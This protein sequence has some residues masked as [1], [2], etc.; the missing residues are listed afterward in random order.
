[1]RARYPDRFQD[2]TALEAPLLGLECQAVKMIP[3][4]GEKL[5]DI[6][7]VMEPVCNDGKS[8]EVE[9]LRDRVARLEA[10]LTN[11][12]NDTPQGS[13]SESDRIVTKITTSVE[14]QVG[15]VMLTLYYR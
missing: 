7:S 9:E 4:E 2:R 15:F 5:K 3:D 8:K 14:I 6:G 12:Y 1:M 11:N 10:L 13:S